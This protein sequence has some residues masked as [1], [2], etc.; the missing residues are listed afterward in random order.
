MVDQEYIPPTTSDPIS[1]PPALLRAAGCVL[2]WLDHRG[3]IVRSSPQA[4]VFLMDEQLEG[5]ALTA[6][7]MPG[8]HTPIQARLLLG[9]AEPQPL[10]LV[11]QLRLP[12]G[13]RPWVTLT[14]MPLDDLAHEA[15]FLVMLQDGSA[16]RTELELPHDA[17]TRYRDLF[18]ATFDAIAV[19]RDNRVLDINP[20][21]EK[22]F[23]TTRSE[24]VGMAQLHYIAPDQHFSVRQH[25]QAHPEA[26]LETTA[27]DKDGQPFPVEVLGKVIDYQGTQVI[28]VTVRDLR[29]QKA[30]ARAI[31]QREQMYRSLARN[32]PNSAVFL[33]DR[34]LTLHIAEGPV[35]NMVPGAFGGRDSEDQPLPETTPEHQR[36]REALRVV[37]NGQAVQDEYELEGRIFR[38]HAVPLF[39]YD[40]AG[41]I[42]MGMALAQDVTEQR[43]AAEQLISSERR[44]WALLS[45]LP[46][47]LYVL[48]SDGVFTAYHTLDETRSLAGRTHD[49]IG[50]HIKD[51][52]LPVSVVNEILMYLELVLETRT[53][54][55]FQYSLETDDETTHFDARMVA[56]N[57]DEVLA[58][59]RDITP[60]KRIQDELSAHVE[61]LTI[62]RQ[63][64]SEL[65]DYLSVDYV[66]QL[67]LDAAMRLSGATSGFVALVNDADADAPELFTIGAYDEGSLRHQMRQPDNL[68]MQANRDHNPLMQVNLPE[69]RAVRPFLDDTVA[70]IALPLISQTR[71][72]FL[73]VVNLET[74]YQGR[75]NED[76]FAFLRLI[77]GRLVSTL[78]NAR[79]YR[80]IQEQLAELKHLYDAVSNLEQLKTD[81]IR[82]ASHDLKNPLGGLMGYQEMLRSEIAS[83]LSDKQ[84][85]YLR[86]MEE[87]A[88]Q[89]QRIVTGILSLERIEQMAQEATSR[90]FDLAELTRK[91]AR[92]QLPHAQLKDQDYQ[93]NVE[94]GALYI[95]GDPL[96]I[97]E[98]LAN[99]ISNA[100][101]YTPAQGTVSVHLEGNGEQISFRV[102]DTGYGVPEAQ[103]KRLFQPFFR[104]KSEQTKKIEGTGLGLHLVKNIV[105]RHGGKMIFQ[106]VEG[107]GSTF[108]FWLPQADAPA[109]RPIDLDA[110]RSMMVG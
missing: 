108:G 72:D 2:L 3:E 106:S 45:A 90:V 103:Q 35:L 86:S 40:D 65:S 89:M 4:G 81:M 70:Q 83:E 7:V 95:M 104:A 37:F 32:L 59:V 26:P 75:F 5:Q 19:E 66:V 110:M 77:T 100:I 61:H 68:V 54:Q 25:L 88:Q 27:I 36:L 47:T 101:K 60:L 28:Y 20:A 23:G 49:L 102:V 93:L 6:L 85:T 76:N 67:G 57:D 46:D 78:E 51:V 38:V 98:A 39:E 22:L 17:D 10:N 96:Q 8:W 84:L 53:P 16:H 94:P 13:R 12:S 56:V 74:R 71:G 64:D 14:L 31:H 80:R 105:E 15:R 44:N 29:E 55:A 107:Q 11:C 92:E 58:L 41:D 30:A 24:A 97:H 21:F 62:L 109:E 79:L 69:T 82:I 34:D 73:G 9:M 63:I 52:D 99:L 42:R 48:R 91:T 33:F 43:L 1:L 18:R 87:A 50:S